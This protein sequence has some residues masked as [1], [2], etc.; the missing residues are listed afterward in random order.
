MCGTHLFLKEEVP[1]GVGVEVEKMALR[2]EG[3]LMDIWA[4]IYCERQAHKGI[5]IGKQGAMLKRIGAAA[6]QDMEWMLGVRV[7]LQLHIKV[8]EDW[9]NSQLAMRELGYE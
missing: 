1:H 8:R 3:G 4:V 9:R 6:R 7:N 2:D 5:L